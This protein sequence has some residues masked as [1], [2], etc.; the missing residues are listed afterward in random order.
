[1][2]KVFKQTLL[3]LKDKSRQGYIG[4]LY[5]DTITKED[6]TSLYSKLSPTTRRPRYL[7]NHK[8]LIL[9]VRMP[10]SRHEDIVDQLKEMIN[11]KLRAAGI[12]R[13]TTWSNLA[14]LYTFGHVSAEPDGCW[15]PA[16]DNNP[17]I[18]M[19]V[20]NSE[21]S[22]QLLLDGRHWLENIHSSVQ[23]SILVKLKKN[24]D[25]IQISIWELDRSRFLRPLRSPLT[26]HRLATRT[27]FAEITRSDPIHR[28][29]VSST[30]SLSDLRI[31]FAIFTGPS[32]PTGVNMAGNM[33]ISQQ[34]LL[35]LGRFH[36]V[37][38][39]GYV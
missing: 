20:G 14:P 27:Q 21:T 19:E 16:S 38:R 6:F 25:V 4:D 11:T 15:G 39:N 18:I 36:F 5:Y 10:A 2:S 34:D 35:D 26:N 9:Q 29:T 24:P 12:D 22:G 13:A 30:Y 8:N 3:D 33:I 17:T 7:Y 31:P 1:M 37:A 28:V 32:P 23:V